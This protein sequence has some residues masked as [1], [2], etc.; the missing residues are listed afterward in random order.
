MRTKRIAVVGHTGDLARAVR[1]ALEKRGHQVTVLMSPNQPASLG[2]AGLDCIV[3]FPFSS[4]MRRSALARKDVDLEYLRSIRAWARGAGVA[5]FVLRSHGIAY[6]SSMKNPGLLDEG[7]TSLLPRESNDRR[8]LEA[9]QI[10]LGA[11]SLEKDASATI[12]AMSRAVVRLTSV[13]SADESDLIPAMLAGRIAAPLAGYDPQ[14]QLLSLQDAAECLACA[15]LSNAEGLFNGSPQGTVPAKAAFKAAVPLRIQ[16]NG[17]LQKPVRTLF[18]KAGIASFPG[19]AMDRIKYNWTISNDR[20]R[21]ELGFE[22]KESS[23]EALR[24]YLRRVGRG[25][26]DRIKDH[27]D[28]FGLDPEYLERW[29]FWFA[30]LRKVYWRVEAEGLEHVPTTEPALVAANHR[31]FM[32]FDG[33]MHRSLILEHRRRH[34]RFLVIPSLFKFPFLC[35]FLIKQGGVVASQT[36]TR[37]LFSRGELVGIFP[38]GINGAFRMYRGAYKLGDMS[39][40]AFARMAIENG[41]PIVPA[42]TVGHV[43]IFPILA[44]VRSSMVVRLTGWPFL[45][46]TPTFPLAPVPLPTKWHIR[47]LEPVPVRGYAPS[48]ANNPRAVNEL[49]ETVR[50]IMQRN[51]DDMLARRKHIFFGDIFEKRTPMEVPKTLGAAR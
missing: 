46:I 49:A 20:A 26:P 11:D 2:P 4:S 7:R 32:P 50:A 36:N 3:A 12:P 35:D 41:V 45:P 21:R 27:Y 40:N 37:K 15:A 14:F 39:R 16:V 18:W 6:G 42:V 19:E 22:P 28:E 10:V 8:W 30:F 9:E 29:S 17:A 48:D 44:K 51:I 38:E 24:G 5:R 43:E 34:I 1:R 23:S 31:G 13:L 47:Y 33:V 25:K